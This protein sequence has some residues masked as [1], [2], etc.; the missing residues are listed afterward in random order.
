MRHGA[1]VD[2]IV[3]NLYAKFNKDRLR[4]EKALGL[5]TRTTTFVALGDPFPGPKNDI[6]AQPTICSL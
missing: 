3:I 1:I 4:N 5:T 2:N 6:K